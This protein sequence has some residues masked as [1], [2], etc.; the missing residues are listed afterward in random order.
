MPLQHSTNYYN[1]FIEVAED[2]PVPESVQPPLKNEKKTI[3]GMQYELIAQHPYQLT[4]DD[5]LFQVHAVRNEIPGDQLI[6]E[7]LSFF[8]KGQACMRASPLAKRYG[9]GIHCN[10]Q[11]CLA[12]YGK[13]TREYRDMLKDKNIKKI[14]AIRSRRTR[15]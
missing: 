12:I 9:F 14:K 15:V 6:E 2:C 7:R 4:S 13:D 3:A 1:T 8:S 5:V 11:G 10:E